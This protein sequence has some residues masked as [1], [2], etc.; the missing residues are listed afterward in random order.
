MTTVSPS[1]R[2]ATVDVTTGCRHTISAEIAGEQAAGHRIEHA[3]EIEPVHQQAD[4]RR[5]ASQRG[6]RPGGAR[7]HDDD[8]E[9]RDRP[10]IIRSDSSVNG[11]A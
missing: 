3:S 5:A 10:T 11:S 9:N 6:I 4:H 2:L 7:Q 8:A 1:T